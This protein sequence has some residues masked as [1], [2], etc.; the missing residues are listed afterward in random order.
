MKVALVCIVKN[1]N[2]YLKE[3]VEYYHDLGIDKIFILDNN[4][5]EYPQDVLDGYDYV[6]IVNYRGYKAYQMKAYKEVIETKCL[7]FDWVCVFD[8]DEFLFLKE[9]KTIKDYLSCGLFDKFQAIL[10]NWRNYGDNNLI[11]YENNYDRN[12]VKRFKKG[13]EKKD[14][15][16]NGKVI[17]RPYKGIVFGNPHAPFFNG[18]RMCNNTGK[19]IRWSHNCLEDWTLS[20]LRHYRK[21]II[22]F[23]EHKLNRGWADGAN[24]KLD[25]NWF[26]QYS[27]RTEEKE[28]VINEYKKS[29]K[30]CVIIPTYKPFDM[31][32]RNE[33]ES[34]LN[35]RDKFK[36]F[37]VW[38]I[39]PESLNQKDYKDKGFKFFKCFNDRYF[40]SVENYNDLML[41]SIFYES[42]KYYEYMLIVQLDSYVFENQLD[43][44]CDLGYDYIGGLHLTPWTGDELINGNGGF[45]LRKI[46]SF[47]EASKNI[48]KDLS[49]R[50]DWEDIL[51][52]YW[53]RNK[54]N[55]A[56]YEVALKFG[57]QQRPEECFNKN[58]KTL[59]FGCHKPFKFDYDVF[60]KE[61]IKNH[62]E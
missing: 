37:H 56:P 61:Y 60:W 51:Y 55:I 9:H 48:K 40:N 52:S 2:E 39:C 27:Q 47:I 29:K 59:P 49:N 5:E 32:T 41:N 43:F 58:G 3:Y 20:E 18:G 44:F 22:E 45:C 38:I 31:L 25:F 62:D 15:V 33:K 11:G 42:F 57:W 28:R 35:T 54:L 17:I 10:V 36:N 8:A 53:Y 13:F 16:T 30:C 46:K 21:T 4:T 24:W 7:D 14:E 19:E 12:I 26:F 1:E 23:I 34:L 6:E 50:W